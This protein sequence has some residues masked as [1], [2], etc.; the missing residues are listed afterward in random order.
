MA[1]VCLS[2]GK[3]SNR[4]VT[5]KIFSSET[6]NAFFS[7]PLFTTLLEGL[8]KNNSTDFHKN[9]TQYCLDVLDVVFYLYL[10]KLVCYKQK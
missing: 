8:L 6:L 5:N 3:L 10:K 7:K 2:K 1:L 4:L 9:F